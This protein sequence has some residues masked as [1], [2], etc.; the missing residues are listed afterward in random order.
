MIMKNLLTNILSAIS[1]FIFLVSCGKDN[2]SL[3]TKEEE[4]PVKE[5]NLPVASRISDLALI[6][7]GG[8]GR[9]PYTPDQMKHYVFRNNAGKPEF[10]YDSFLFLEI[11]T[12]INGQLFDFGVEGEGRKV[13]GKSE[14]TWL[15]DETFAKDRGPDAIERTIDSL[16]QLGYAP[17]TKR[18]VVF[19]IPNPIF[20]NKSWGM[21]DN[22]SMDLSKLE[23]RFKTASW[24]VNQVEERWK[25]KNYKYIELVGYYWLHET[26]DTF[27]QDD[28]LVDQVGTLVKGMK[29]DFIWVPY[30]GAQRA[31]EWKEQGF[32]KAY[33]QPNY[34]FDLNSPMSILTGA[35]DFALRYNMELE[36]E[37]DGR[38]NQDSYR[39]KYYDYIEKFEEKGV[40]K[41]KQVAYYDGGGAWYSMSIS[42]DANMK[43]MVKSLGDIIVKRQKDLK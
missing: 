33:Q 5:V 23:D 19:A 4:K 42:K 7:H 37:Y 13:P 40:W 14:W 22:R 3:P 8:S 32:T 25:K 43:G 30:Y 21:I 9:I 11:Y 2:P 41:D 10:L 28:L 1:I 20:G 27:N 38:V 31:H 34:F 12:T 24:Y 35:I 26:I 16:V 39:Q 29:R 36:F 15:L 18:K 6:Y 17:P